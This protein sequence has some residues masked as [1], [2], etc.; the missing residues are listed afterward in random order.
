MIQLTIKHYFEFIYCILHEKLNFKNKHL[1][2]NSQL[3]CTITLKY[4]SISW[5]QI[6]IDFEL[7]SKKKFHHYYYQIAIK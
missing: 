1:I 4:D 6:K 5:Q 3:K 7:I 2:K